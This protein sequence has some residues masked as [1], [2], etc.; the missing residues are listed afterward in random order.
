MRFLKGLLLLAVL[1]TLF[2]CGEKIVHIKDKKNPD[3]PRNI[4]SLSP[5]MTELVGK[6]GPM[7]LLRGRTES[8]NYPPGVDKL[9]AVA[10]VKPN[11]EAIATLQPKPDLAVYDSSL[12]KHEEP[13]KL[14]DL[15]IKTYKLEANTI[16]DFVLELYKMGQMFGT[17]ST[18]SRYADQ[19]HQ[20]TSYAEGNVKNKNL[21]V[22]ILMGDMA[23]GVKSFYADIVRKAGGQPVGPDT[24]EYTSMSPEQ[25]VAANP[26]VI[27]DVNKEAFDEFERRAP[28]DSDRLKRQDVGVVAVLRE[29]LL[30]DPRY[31]SITAIKQK[32]VRSVRPDM[33]LR[34]G[35]RVDL[36]I[37]GIANYLST[38]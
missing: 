8:C 4:I 10:G 20:A 14:K 25:I 31:Q 13:E 38:F 5:G 1:F 32:Q 3:P 30:N 35:A 36:M 11:Y 34:K 2:G 29:D 6:Y 7:T 37:K 15:G 24:D 17:E 21:K 12:F 33:I 18:M 28:S 26:D 9:P 22:M 27:L 16:D 23:A 19:I